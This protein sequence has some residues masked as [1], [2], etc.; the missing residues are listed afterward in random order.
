MDT[1]CVFSWCIFLHVDR[2]LR[3]LRSDW[4]GFANGNFYAKL[5][6]KLST[7]ENY[8]CYLRT[9]WLRRMT[10]IFSVLPFNGRSLKIQPSEPWVHDVGR[11]TSCRSLCQDLS[12]CET[13]W[14]F[15]LF[16]YVWFYG[17]DLGHHLEYS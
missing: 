16:D 6:A 10:K 12:N 3:F 17:Y 5:S 4:K 14:K 1:D 2:E 7:W 15:I 8:S 11:T 13:G 9:Q